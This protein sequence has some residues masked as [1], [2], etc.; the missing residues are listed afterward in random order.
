MKKDR[1]EEAELRKKLEEEKAK[2]NTVERKL[3]HDKEKEKEKEQKD[4]CQ[5]EKETSHTY[6][7]RA[8]D[9]LIGWQ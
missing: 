8:H 7:E 1:R 6:A 4:N 9:S 2:I 5:K 3:K